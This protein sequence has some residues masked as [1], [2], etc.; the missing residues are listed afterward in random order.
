VEEEQ[1]MGLL[2][3]RSRVGDTAD[4]AVAQLR[5]GA[6]DV[7]DAVTGAVGDVAAE[8]GDRVGTQV[9]AA[10]RDLA[11]RIDPAPVPRRG[12]RLLVLGLLVTTVSAVVWAVLARRPQPA[13]QSSPEHLPSTVA[14]AGDDSTS[15]S[16]TD[17]LP[18]S[19]LTGDPESRGR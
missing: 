6:H 7:L 14:A 4:V 9:T 3:R 15:S 17:G 1:G 18:T 12:L 5:R 16:A 11:D 10:R 2:G 8:L 13:P 19:G